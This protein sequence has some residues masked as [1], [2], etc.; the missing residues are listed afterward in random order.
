MRNVT[1]VDNIINYIIKKIKHF[2][3]EAKI[4]FMQHLHPT[5]SNLALEYI[6]TSVNQEA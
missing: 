4:V 3:C 1:R 6:H 5:N 2:R